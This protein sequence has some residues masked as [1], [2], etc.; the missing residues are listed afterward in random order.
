M[1][2]DNLWWAL[3]EQLSSSPASSASMLGGPLP[4][5]MGTHANNLI[6]RDTI[7]IWTQFSTLTNTG[8]NIHAFHLKPIF[9]P[10]L[11]DSSFQEWFE[12][13]ICW[14]GDLFTDGLFDSF[15]HCVRQHN[16][17]KSNFFRNLQICNFTHTHFPSKPSACPLDECLK[18]KPC[19]S[20]LSGVLADVALFRKWKA[21]FSG[22]WQHSGRRTWTWSFL[23]KSG[24]ELSKDYM[25]RQFV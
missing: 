4:L 9:K 7:R 2:R 18:I 19:L 15:D 6:F 25:H 8:F 20:G 13:G 1:N 5:T 16:L 11:T 10:S 3:L 24:K 12:R 23:R 21:T 14:V 17:P 22:T